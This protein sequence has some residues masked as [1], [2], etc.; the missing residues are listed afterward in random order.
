MN[1]EDWKAKREA[2]IQQAADRLRNILRA[3]DAEGRKQACNKLIEDA[4]SL[5]QDL[6]MLFTQLV[7]ITRE[8][9]QNILEE[10]LRKLQKEMDLEMLAME[11]V[12]EGFPYDW[13][14]D[15]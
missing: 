11:A 6:D 5:K 7:V 15:E 13:P 3:E 10:K 2:K 12:Y 4:G 14:S 1:E 8:S 9:H